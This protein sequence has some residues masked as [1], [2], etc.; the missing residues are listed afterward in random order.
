M[1]WQAN[2]L[3]KNKHCFFGS[4]GGFSKGKY[5]KLNANTKSY[6]DKNALMKNL[7]TIA[8]KVGLAKEKLLL[9]NQG[10]SNVAVYVDEAN[11]DTVVADGTV[12]TKKG[13]GL[14]IRTADCAPV[15]FEDRVNGV[16]GAA[17]AGWRGAFK[18]IME[19]VIALMIEKGAELKNIK[20]A[21]GPCVMQESY[22]VDGNFYNQF[23]E[24]AS[25]N[26][27]YFAEGKRKNHFYFD[28]PNYCLDRLKKAGIENVEVAY[29]DTYALKDEYFSF[30]RFTHQGLVDEPKDFPCQV[31]VI[32][33]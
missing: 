3:D 5:A 4:G 20:A 21:I 23:L 28:L 6:D 17:H 11:W 16:V 15:L 29:L 26:K 25:E 2:N 13:I 31:S 19:N 8:E 7:Q 18:G 32:T 30:R 10:V 14:C 1:S 9:L 27:K 33:L 24:Q 22:E 12:T